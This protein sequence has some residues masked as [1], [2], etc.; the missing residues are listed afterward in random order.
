MS[1]GLAFLYVQMYGESKKGSSLNQLV[2]TCP[3][4]G[5]DKLYVYLDSDTSYC[6]RCGVYKAYN[7]GKTVISLEEL[8]NTLK[9]HEELPKELSEIK[10]PRNFVEL[11]DSKAEKFYTEYLEGR[12]FSTIDIERSRLL[13]G[14]ETTSENRT[15][16]LPVY[17]YHQLVYYTKRVVKPG[18]NRYE[19]P[20]TE[21]VDNKKTNI[22][23]NFDNARASSTVVVCEGVF[24]AMTVG[25]NAI[26]TFGKSLSEFQCR[27]IEKNWNKIILALD[28][29]AWDKN[30][31]LWKRFRSKGKNVKILDIPG[32][33]DL[34]DA[35]RELVISL[36]M[37]LEEDKFTE[38]DLLRYSL[39]NA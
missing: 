12:G 24:D 2:F 7:N 31:S 27:L 6:F 28:P 26:A 34:N 17:M 15:I 35:G 30:V 19:N 5:R 36:L 1:R 22:L 39:R 16:L 21:E 4:C 37:K 10:V 23:F 9:R 18:L 25:V 14:L 32:H 38:I 3:D 8:K 11:R 29:D 13:F 20:K 33:K